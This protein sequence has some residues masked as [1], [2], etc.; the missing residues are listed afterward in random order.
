MLLPTAVM[1]QTAPKPDADPRVTALV[2]AVS[3]VRLRQLVTTLA[4]FG[5]RESMSSTTSATRGIG[6]AR[7][8]IFDELQRSSPRLQVSF[9]AHVLAPQGRVLRQ[10]ELRNVIAILPGRTARRIYVT[11]HYDSLN[12]GTS[13]AARN[14]GAAANPQM[15]P[16]FDH[17]GAADGA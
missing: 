13:Q 11:G 10:T 7:Q 9:D 5:T 2:A 4:G 15:R 8:W 17:E 6:A 16:D 12:L 3:E 1:A 14:T